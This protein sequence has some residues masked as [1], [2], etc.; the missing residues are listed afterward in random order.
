MEKNNLRPL[1][2][3]MHTYTIHFSGFGEYYGYKEGEYYPKTM[4]F[5]QLM[6]QAVDWGLDGLHIHKSDLDSTDS[7]YLA[8]I[9]AAAKEKNLYLELNCSFK[10][11]IDP[12]VNCSVEEALTLADA[13]GADLVK[14]SLDII[15]P[16][17]LYRSYFHP[18]VMKQLIVRYEQFKE[19]IPLIEKLKIKVALEN[20]TDTY[21]DE[22]LWVVN[23]LN[24]SMIGTCI[25][26]TNSLYVLEDP[27]SAMDKMLPHAFCTH[28]S[29]DLI[30]TNPM[31]LRVVG[32]PMGKGSF[33]AARMLQE[34]R[35]KA[36]MD[37]INFENDSYFAAET[38]T[39][40]Q[41]RVREWAECEESIRYLREELMIGL[42]GR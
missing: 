32:V 15:R 24:H 20:H 11:F 40:E 22:V 26:T 36:P 1:A 4:T 35:D 29:D 37:R 33:D 34:I 38:E 12:R 30:S 8:E 19:A 2:L 5:M 18:D 31:G 9:K 27:A 6:D 17:I 25:D 39:L 13:I 10:S 28:F 14:F 42:R 16:R 21:T 23:W 7:V 3:G 41:A